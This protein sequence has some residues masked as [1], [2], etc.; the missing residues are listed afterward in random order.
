[1]KPKDEASRRVYRWALQSA[2]RQLLPK[3]RVTWCFRRVVP[4]KTGVDVLHSPSVK[5]AHYRN[6]MICA[7]LWICPVCAS[8]ISERRRVELTHAIENAKG[9]RVALVTFTM[10]HERRDKLTSLL[11]DLLASFRKLKA[12]RQWQRVE[13]QFGVVGSVRALEVTHWLNGWHCHLHV[14]FFF[15]KDADLDKL[16]SVMSERWRAVL[17]ENGRTA[18]DEHGVDVSTRDGDVARYVA[19]YGHEPTKARW[20]IEHEV[21][22]ASSKIGAYDHRTPFQ[23]LGDYMAGDKRSGYLFKEYAAAFKGKRQLVWSRG[24]RAALRIGKEETDEEIAKRFEQDAVVLATLSLEQWKVILANDARAEVLEVASSG[25]AGKLLDYVH[26][27][28]GKADRRYMAFERVMDNGRGKP[29][30]LQQIGAT[31]VP[32]FDKATL[33][34]GGDD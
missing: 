7:S 24:L 28:S 10:H 16:R 22:K 12:G 31:Q 20:N 27:L 3:E 19:K 5:R 9:M 14:L 30:M 8:K 13:S 21:V 1:M 6:L 18:D 2:A 29:D 34:A 17:A 11:D 32:G 15:P 25:D 26:S 33:W 23:I 4:G